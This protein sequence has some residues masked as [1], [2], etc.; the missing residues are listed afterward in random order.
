MPRATQSTFI[1]VKYGEIIHLLSAMDI[2]VVQSRIVGCGVGWVF[3]RIGQ[4]FQ[5]GRPG[6]PTYVYGPGELEVNLVRATDPHP[7]Q[8]Y[9]IMT[10]PPKASW[11]YLL[12]RATHGGCGLPMIDS[13]S[14]TLI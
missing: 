12:R 8:T 11:E 1:G 13:F 5:E 6:R 2:P 7:D 10:V 14:M 9:C 3:R 4:H